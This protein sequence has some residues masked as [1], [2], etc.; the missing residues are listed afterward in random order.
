MEILSGGCG[1]L[2]LEKMNLIGP[3]VYIIQKFAPSIGTDEGKI[4][5]CCDISKKLLNF[6]IAIKTPWESII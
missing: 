3:A 1:D 2:S 6:Y 5:I 4:Y